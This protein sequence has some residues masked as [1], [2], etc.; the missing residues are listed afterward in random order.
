[1]AILDTNLPFRCALTDMTTLETT[2]RRLILQIIILSYGHTVASKMYAIDVF[3]R[4]RIRF[5]LNI[6]GRVSVQAICV[7]T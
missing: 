3:Y 4:L 1:M 7:R 5:R 2:Q 6:I